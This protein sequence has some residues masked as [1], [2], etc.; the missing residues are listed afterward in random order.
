MK[1][2][3]E[4]RMHSSVVTQHFS[5]KFI[6]SVWIPSL[7]V[8]AGLIQH[9]LCIYCHTD[10]AWEEALSYACEETKPDIPFRFPIQKIGS[11]ST[12]DEKAN[13]ALLLPN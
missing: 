8:M 7:E 10:K 11:S 4:V 13:V 2:V 3:P 5:P 9:D 12:H 6:G 1:S